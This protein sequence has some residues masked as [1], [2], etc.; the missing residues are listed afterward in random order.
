MKKKKELEVDT[1]MYERM[2]EHLY[3]KKP[4]LGSDSPFSE[5]LILLLLFVG[6]HVES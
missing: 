4:L 1:E 3:S 6:T 5:M 2:K